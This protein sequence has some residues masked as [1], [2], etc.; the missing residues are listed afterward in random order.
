MMPRLMNHAIQS[1]TGF[2][3]GLRLNQQ[4][5][6]IP[7]KAGIHWRT[8]IPAFA[9]MTKRGRNKDYPQQNKPTKKPFPELPVEK[10]PFSF[11]WYR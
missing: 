1:L 5:P 2:G 4:L 9:G 11:C 7:A 8:W 10:R 6:V 3:Y